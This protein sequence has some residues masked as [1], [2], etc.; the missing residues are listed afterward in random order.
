MTIR[1]LLRMFS[2]DLDHPSSMRLF[3][4]LVIGVV[5]FNWTYATLREGR[6]VDLDLGAVLALA[7]AFGGKAAQKGLEG[8]R[9]ADPAEPASP[10]NQAGPANPAS[11][12]DL[13]REAGPTAQGEKDP[14]ASR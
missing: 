9:S 2:D 5:L 13:S 10:A 6:W 1:D 8:L 4:A 3:A 11:P 7:A 12:A 14:G